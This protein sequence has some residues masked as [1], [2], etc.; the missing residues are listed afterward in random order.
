MCVRGRYPLRPLR[1]CG[2]CAYRVK[3]TENLKCP[4]CR[5]D[6]RSQIRSAVEPT[7]TAESR[8]RPKR[9][10][11]DLHTA[12][13]VEE[14]VG[15]DPGA[16]TAKYK[17]NCYVCETAWVAGASVAKHRRVET[18][19]V[20]VQCVAAE[21]P[22]AICKADASEAGS[23]LKNGKNE[24]KRFFCRSC[25]QEM[26]ERGDAKPIVGATQFLKRTAR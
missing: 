12:H 26:H 23:V 15:V 8:H 21:M 9:D 6:I 3:Q 10:K 11:G 20:C 25:V 4:T 1:L 13:G 14:G 16:F 18:K 22:C 24:L 2:G 7:E 17:G 19:A 5:E